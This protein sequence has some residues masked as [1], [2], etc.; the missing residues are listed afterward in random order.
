MDT[1]SMIRSFLARTL[2]RL[3]GWLAP[4]T[5]SFSGAWAPLPM[6]RSGQPT[7]N[8]L[9]CELKSTAWTCASLNAAVCASFPPRL[10]VRT[11]ARG[12][13]ARCLTRSLSEEEERR[14]R[15]QCIQ[16]RGASRIEEVLE[17]PLL[18]LLAQMNPVHNQFDLLELTTLY[19]EVY[20]VA[21]WLL[22]FG[23][24]NTPVAIWPLPTHQV[25]PWRSPDSTQL[26]DAYVY[27][28][29]AEERRYMPEQIVAFR[30]PD[31]RDP[32]LAGL[33][34][35]RACFEQ[36]QLTSSLTAFKQARFVNHAIPDA[37]VS[38]DYAI[39]E[40]ERER[41]ELRWNERLRRGGAGR[42][43]IT[44]NPVRVQMLQ[45]SMGDLAALADA[46]ATKED[47]CNAFGVPMAFLT[48][49]TNLANLQAAQQQHLAQG[50][51][52]RLRRRDEK[53]NEQLV[54]L[55]DPSG[56]LFLATEEPAPGD[57]AQW[58]REREVLLRH[59][60]MTI[61]EVRSEAGLPAV[62]WG[63]RARG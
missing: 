49:Q 28:S 51:R 35:L 17:H 13:Q 46:R 29:G 7:T 18:D 61:N 30:Y 50:I 39:G 19:Q 5:P 48:S 31:P 3:A 37:I 4:S 8:D 22:E 25:T 26:V 47:I 58:I 36:V 15:S 59:G 41:L 55:F 23:P 53:L 20:G 52:P 2:S 16:T 60:V 1:S 11:N 14:L 12:P 45:H 56:R 34:P 38:A 40:E 54:P 6:N 27:R 63:E 44:Q 21:Y 10:Y 57:R 24:L 62:A 33:S 32:Y 43:L 9:L 42:V